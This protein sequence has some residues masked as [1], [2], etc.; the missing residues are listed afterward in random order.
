[1]DESLV[2]LAK[3]TAIKYGLDPALVCAVCEQESNWNSWA[4]RFEP[5]FLARYVQPLGL[6]DLTEIQ[7]RA[8]SF[9]LMQLMGEVARELGYKGSI[10]QLCDPPIGLVLGC[11]H[12]ANKFKQAGG[13]THK[14]LLLWNGGG[15][16]DYPDQVLAR[17]SK[18]QTQPDLSTGTP[19][20][21]TNQ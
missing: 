21:P 7:E 6:H 16:L 10:V 15:I 20:L 4:S 8:F 1:M 12:L 11:Q 5:R 9:G 2:Q 18:Y 17:V 13:D 3:Q 14:A 19:V